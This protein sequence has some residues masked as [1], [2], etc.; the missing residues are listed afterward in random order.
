M[1]DYAIDTQT[2]LGLDTS[3]L[4]LQAFASGVSGNNS[5]DSGAQAALAFAGPDAGTLTVSWRGTV[6]GPQNNSVGNAELYALAPVAGSL[7]N[8]NPNAGSTAATYAFVVGGNGSV[9]V[10]WSFAT[11]DTRDS[12]FAN[13]FNFGRRPVLTTASVEV[14]HGGGVVDS[15]DTGLATQTGSGATTLPFSALAG[16]TVVLRLMPRLGLG[17]SSSGT[18]NGQIMED[19]TVHFSVTAV[20]EPHVWW[21]MGAGLACIAGWRRKQ[22]PA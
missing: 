10:D 14:W 2:R 6:F 22:R 4:S 19:I 9:A 11:S 1:P 5:V 16:D 3:T 13:S 8:A 7:Y 18:I 20:P 21:L 17:Y 15:R 12:A